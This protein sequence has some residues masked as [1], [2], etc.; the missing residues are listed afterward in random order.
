MSVELDGVN[1]ILKTDTVSEVTSANGV[2]IDGVS[3]KDGAVTATGVVTGAGFT[4]G[5]AVLA[6]AELELLDGLTAGTAIASKV[7]TTDGSIDTAGQRNLTISGELDAA[8]LDISGAIDIAGASVLHGLLTH[9]GGAVFN[10]ASADVDFRVETNT[11]AN[12]LFISG[13]NNVV[14]IGG[15]GAIGVGLHIIGDDG[16]ISGASAETHANEFV[17]ENDGNAGMTIIS[18]N[19]SASILNFG[20]AEDNNI[21][22]FKYTHDGNVFNI[23][24]VGG[25]NSKA[26]FFHCNTTTTTKYRM[27]VASTGAENAKHRMI[28]FENA[29]QG[30]GY[31]LSGDGDSDAPTFAAGSDRR[32]KK[33]ITAYTGGYAKIKSIPVQQWDE[34]YSSKKKGKVGWIADELDDVFPEAIE[35]T[36]NATKDVVNAILDKDGRLVEENKKAEYLTE[37]QAIGNYPNCT[38]SE[39]ATVPIYQYSSPLTIFPDV[40]QALQKAIEKIEVLETKVK[41]LE[42]A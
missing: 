10:E 24:N 29:S 30:R 27:M 39:S 33:N 11:N 34:K 41:T 9:D 21:G 23:N 4:A 8:T 18:A 6:E 32:L 38:F 19:D 3:L 28:G 37:Q 1:N 15:E 26:F 7:V 22:V 35:G 16:V 2:T 40:V 13:G 12:M 14:G 31:I 5:S 42:D 17:I 36:A 25:D 20:D